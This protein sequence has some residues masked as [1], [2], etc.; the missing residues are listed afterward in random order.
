MQ[1]QTPKVSPRKAITAAFKRGDKVCPIPHGR[2]RRPRTVGIVLKVLGPKV[3]IARFK[4]QPK[5]VYPT[6]ALQ[7]ASPL[8]L[9]VFAASGRTS[10]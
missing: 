7:K 10:A 2:P 4:G 5:G 9:S 8:P 1:V 6:W 3:V